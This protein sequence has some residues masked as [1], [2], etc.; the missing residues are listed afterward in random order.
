MGKRPH[1]YQAKLKEEYKYLFYSLRFPN[2]LN[3]FLIQYMFL[4]NI[5]FV[6]KK[7]LRYIRQNN[8][9]LITVLTKKISKEPFTKYFDFELIKSFSK[10]RVKNWTALERLLA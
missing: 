4:E 10:K 2:N 5:P 3:E 9:S 7:G 6:S 8:D 1:V